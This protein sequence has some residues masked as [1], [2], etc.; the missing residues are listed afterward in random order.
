MGKKGKKSKKQIEEEL[1]KAEEE[2]VL[3]LAD[4]VARKQ[5]EQL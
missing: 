1:L 3:R 4:E 2:Q 5:Q